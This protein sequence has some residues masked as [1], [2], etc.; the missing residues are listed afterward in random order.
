MLVKKKIHKVKMNSKQKVE[1]K[2][3]GM[4]TTNSASSKESKEEKDSKK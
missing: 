2:K 3:Y 4:G 1:N